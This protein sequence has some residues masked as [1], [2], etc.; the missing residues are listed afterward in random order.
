MSHGTIILFNRSFLK[1]SE[2]S[3]S[4]VLYVTEILK[5]LLMNLGLIK[6]LICG[7]CAQVPVVQI[8]K[9]SYEVHVVYVVNVL[10]GNLPVC[11]LE[12]FH[13]R[14]IL[15]VSHLKVLGFALFCFNQPRWLQTLSDGAPPLGKIYPI[16]KNCRNF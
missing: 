13:N 5:S 14:D 9:V 8:V 11:C 1:L 15:E 2:L 10:G 4:W 7:S 12:K 6:D 3:P 16:Q